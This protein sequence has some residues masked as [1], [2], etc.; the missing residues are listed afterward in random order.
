M[1]V[2]VRPTRIKGYALRTK[3]RKDL[4]PVVGFLEVKE[5]RIARLGRSTIAAT[6]RSATDPLGNE[7]L[8]E[9][10]DV[11]LLWISANQLRLTGVEMLEDREFMQTWDV[12]VV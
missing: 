9:I 2:E 12:R 7:V 1:K 5:A 4:P 8:V 11:R 6:V 3:D 10:T